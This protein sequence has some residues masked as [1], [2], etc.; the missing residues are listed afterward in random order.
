MFYLMEG[1]GGLVF[2][3]ARGY[4]EG[5][6]GMKKDHRDGWKGRGMARNEIE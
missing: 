6:D 2:D 5:R 4:R 1:E 3:I